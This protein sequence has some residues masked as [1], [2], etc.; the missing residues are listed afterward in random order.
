VITRRRRQV[1]VC[2]R[3]VPLIL[4]RSSPGLPYSYGG[5]SQAGIGR[6][7]WSHQHLYVRTNGETGN[8]DC[9]SK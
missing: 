3:N 6:R 2:G 4:M 8:L 5:G 9:K 1:S 7:P